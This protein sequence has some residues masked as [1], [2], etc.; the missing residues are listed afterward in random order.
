MHGHMN[1]KWVQI[2]FP[3]MSDSEIRSVLPSFWSKMKE[4]SR[5]MSNY[6]RLNYVFTDLTPSE[7]KLASN[8]N[9]SRTQ[10]LSRMK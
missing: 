7:I 1:V 6:W 3:E 4:K 8:W 2:P 5:H 10:T 9:I